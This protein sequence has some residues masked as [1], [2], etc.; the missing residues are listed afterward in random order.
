MP[1][2]RNISLA[3]IWGGLCFILLYRTLPAELVLSAQVMHQY[4]I[5]VSQMAVGWLVTALPAL[6]P[7]L[8]FIALVRR[9][10]AAL[11]PWLVLPPVAWL[12]I[13]FALAVGAGTV[14]VRAGLTPPWSETVSDLVFRLAMRL[15]S[16]HALTVLLTTL[17][18]SYACWREYRSTRD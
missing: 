9:R 12:L 18:C 10:Q 7:L 13:Q 4:G 5:P 6:M 11:W 1:Q 15:W 3:L 17:A 14:M 16:V 8:C 2:A